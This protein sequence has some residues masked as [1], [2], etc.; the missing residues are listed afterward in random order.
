MQ[1]SVRMV[2]VA[3]FDPPTQAEESPAYGSSSIDPVKKTDDLLAKSHQ[4]MERY[5][6]GIERPPASFAAPTIPGSQISLTK[7]YDVPAESLEAAAAL[8]HRFDDV[9]SKFGMP[10]P[11]FGPP[12]YVGSVF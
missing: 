11:N 4:L 7:A 6:K 1:L 12:T 2:E 10:S 5:L 8:L 9:A 3:D